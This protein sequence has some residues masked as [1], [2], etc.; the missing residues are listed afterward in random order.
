MR[1]IFGIATLVVIGIII[2]DLVAHPDAL[3]AGGRALNGLIVPSFQGLLGSAPS[4]Y[5]PK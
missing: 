5:Q 3:T 4:G 1:P 2:A